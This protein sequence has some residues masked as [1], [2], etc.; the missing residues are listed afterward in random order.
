MKQ[1]V[2]AFWNLKQKNHLNACVFPQLVFFKCIHKFRK[3]KLKI[4]FET[5]WN[6]KQLVKVF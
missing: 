5:N 4:Q 6:M 2:Q 3:N 1:V